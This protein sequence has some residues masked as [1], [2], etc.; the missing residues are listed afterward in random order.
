MKYTKIKEYLLLEH[1]YC[2]LHPRKVRVSPHLLQNTDIS[3]LIKYIKMVVF[4]PHEPNNTN[5]PGRM[6]T[7][8]IPKRYKR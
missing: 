2:S 3:L 1:Q 8:L 6:L 7:R 4:N 5:N